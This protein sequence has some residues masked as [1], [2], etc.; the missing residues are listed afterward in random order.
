MFFYVTG[1]IRD[2]DFYLNVRILHQL[3]TSEYAEL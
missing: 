1:K 3:K 2:E